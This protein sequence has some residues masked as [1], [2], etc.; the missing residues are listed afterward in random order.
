[1]GGGGQRCVYL[2]RS[3]FI[4]RNESGIVSADHNRD[5]L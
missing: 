2:I 3:R 1:M 4:E 5:A